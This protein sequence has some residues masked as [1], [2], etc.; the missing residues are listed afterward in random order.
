MVSMY[1]ENTD[2]EWMMVR[3]KQGPGKMSSSEGPTDE[4]YL[5]PLPTFAFIKQTR[6]SLSSS[7]FTHPFKKT[8]THIPSLSRLSTK[9]F[10]TKYFKGKL[11]SRCM[12][13]L[14]EMIRHCIYWSF[15]HSSK[16]ILLMWYQMKPSE[17]IQQVKKKSHQPASPRSQRERQVFKYILDNVAKIHTMT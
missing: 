2:T 8:H 5:S 6:Y 12:A 7:Q 1:S 9:R 13:T 10:T 4:Q 3:K 15:S 16:C 11:L 14:D 17:N